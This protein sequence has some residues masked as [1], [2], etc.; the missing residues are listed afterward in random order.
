MVFDLNL[1]LHN[2]QR[3]D[4]PENVKKVVEAPE[5]NIV[6]PSSPLETSPNEFSFSRSPLV[7][8]VDLHVLH[9]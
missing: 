8:S 2:I 5:D 6:N 1:N 4:E 3:A 7:S 9:S